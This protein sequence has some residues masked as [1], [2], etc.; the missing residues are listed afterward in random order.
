MPWKPTR[1]PF[2]KKK[3]RIGGL[4]HQTQP[5]CVL[6]CKQ[7]V[8]THPGRLQKFQALKGRVADNHRVRTKRIRPLPKGGSRCAH[9]QG[10]TLHKKRVTRPVRAESKDPEGG[11]PSPL[12]TLPHHLPGLGRKCLCHGDCR[13]PP[14]YADTAATTVTASLNRIFR[15]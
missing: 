7:V 6:R 8:K 9:C 5:A 13:R 14:R 12:Q 2:Q 1:Y 4:G 10:E 3:G 15:R 11:R